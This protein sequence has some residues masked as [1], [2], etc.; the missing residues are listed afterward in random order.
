MSRAIFRSDSLET[1]T[2]C[3]LIKEQW[4]I[5]RYYIRKGL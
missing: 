3:E 5:K 1:I 4:K 2:G